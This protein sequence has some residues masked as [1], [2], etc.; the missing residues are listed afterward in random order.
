MTISRRNFVVLA[1]STLPMLAQE[2]AKNG[3][4]VRVDAKYVCFVT[5][6]RF[7]KEQLPVKV[8]GKTYYGCCEMCKAKLK[9]DAAQR[10]D[11]DPV[12]GAKVDKASAVIGADSQG[13]VYFFENE[14]NLKKFKPVA[15]TK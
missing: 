3:S 13:K 5:K 9:E 4:L 12:S 10:C 11:L 15:E 7:D 1:A 14:D 8:E 2:S 6:H